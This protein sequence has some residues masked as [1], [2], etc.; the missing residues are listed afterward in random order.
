MELLGQIADERLVRL[1]E[2]LTY[3]IAIF[4]V[5]VA[6]FLYRR[7]IA[8]SH[9]Q[10]EWEI[11]ESV[12]EKYLEFI[13]AALAQPRVGVVWSEPDIARDDLPPA[14]RV[15]QDLL[16]DLLCSVFERAFIVYQRARHGQRQQQWA[17][18]LGWIDEYASRRNFRAW[19]SAYSES[20]F[21]SNQYDTE[22]ERFMHDRI[23]TVAARREPGPA[24]I[25]RS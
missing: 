13:N 9:E 2:G 21:P 24:H 20:G 3:L 22:F 8:A 1:L 5:P 16:F 11:Y 10:R 17:G 12:Q 6:I 15:T 18:W 4:G 19:W 23:A 14:E 7:D 25:D